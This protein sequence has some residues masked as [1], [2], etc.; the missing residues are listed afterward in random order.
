VTFD[1]TAHKSATFQVRFGFSI[2]QING[3]DVVSSWNVDDVKL[4]NIPCP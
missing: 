4:S 1:V 2:G 3:L